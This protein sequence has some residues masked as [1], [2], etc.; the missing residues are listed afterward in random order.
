MKSDF[1]IDAD[2]LLLNFNLPDIEF[3]LTINDLITDFSCFVA[4]NT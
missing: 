1:F 3:F 4:E 2:M